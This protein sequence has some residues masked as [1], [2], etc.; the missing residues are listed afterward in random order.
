MRVYFSSRN[1]QGKAQIGRFDFNPEDRDSMGNLAA[2]PVLKLGSLGAFDDS[3]V[4][5]SC[6][7][8]RENKK[9]LYYS[10]WSLGVTVPFY[11]RIG[12]AE[13]IDGGI[14]FQRVSDGPVLG[15]DS[16]DPYLTASPC[17]LIEGA[18][19]RMWYVSC[20][21]WSLDPDGKPRHHYL[22]KYAE[23]PDGIRWGLDR[24][25]CID[26]SGPD[27]Y[28]IGRPCVV[29]NAGGYRMWYCHRGSSYRIGYAESKDGIRWE[30][31]DHLAG[32]EGSE[33]GW[34][35]EMQAYPWVFSHR[36]RTYMLYNGNGYGKSGMGMA[37]LDG[38]QSR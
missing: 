35:S 8:S 25:V 34:D 2:E 15:Q 32:I 6:I 1:V 7:V 14:T 36:N 20:I 17:V 37:T 29:K 28:A 11:L 23:S 26:F 33:E 21:K 31:L 27:E 13:S 24:P 30:R 16:A 4:T 22:I 19:W 3:G 38:T 18:V 10:G 9:Y 5:S 12:L